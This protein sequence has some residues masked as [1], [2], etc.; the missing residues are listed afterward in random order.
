VLIGALV[1]AAMTGRDSLA[2]LIWGVA[3]A[4][5]VQF[6][7][8][9][10]AVKQAGLG[11]G[12][13]RPRLTEDVKRVLT[14]GLPGVLAAGV[15]QINLLVGTNIASAQDGAASWLYYADRLYQLPL[16]VIGIALS[17]ALLPDL[18]RRLRAGD[19]DRRA[20]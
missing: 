10:F 4:G 8:V 14:L 7:M 13:Q 16:G 18:S 19:E 11:I 2:S 6:L 17:V 9:W 5:G 1:L 3:I 12:L 15:G 20:Q